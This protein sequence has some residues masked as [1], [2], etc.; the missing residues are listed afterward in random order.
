MTK[1]DPQLY[2]RISRSEPL[3]RQ[4]G[5]GEGK[6]LELPIARLGRMGE[7]LP[8]GPDGGVK[9][10]YRMQKDVILLFSVLHLFSFS[11]TPGFLVCSSVVTFSQAVTTHDGR[12]HRATQN[13]HSFIAQSRS[14]SVLIV[15]LNY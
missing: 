5:A 1:M 7:T 8:H 9:G 6:N 10:R 4:R 14:R 15:L 13:S 2:S 11:S 3:V 12:T